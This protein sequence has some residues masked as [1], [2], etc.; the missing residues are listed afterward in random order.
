MCG[1]RHSW[2]CLVTTIRNSGA[3]NSCASSIHTASV[4]W[5]FRESLPPHQSVI[6]LPCSSSHLVVQVLGLGTDT[7]ETVASVLLFF[8]RQRY[9]F[10]AG[11]GF[12]RFTVEYKIKL[13][14][15]SRILVSRLTTDAT[16]G[17]PGYPRRPVGSCCS[18]V[19]LLFF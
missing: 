15:L 4:L 11:E 10:N 7:G 17:L 12:Q 13:N 3:R 2:A 5:I 18:T 8:D 14:R 19:I 16:G 9:V 1:S 6:L